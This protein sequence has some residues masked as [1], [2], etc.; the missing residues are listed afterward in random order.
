[1]SVKPKDIATFLLGAAAGAAALKYATM[2]DEEKEKM[3]NA[4]KDKANDLKS[5]AET[6]VENAKDYFSELKTK[7]SEY[8]KD[9]WAEAEKY[10]QEIFK[11]KLKG[12]ELVEDV[13]DGVDTAVSHVDSAAEDVKDKLDDLDTEEG[14]VYPA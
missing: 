3:I 6:T 13:K 10:L 5:Q 9:N 11:G 8:L 14:K 7:S 12:E 2:S 1:M 4:V